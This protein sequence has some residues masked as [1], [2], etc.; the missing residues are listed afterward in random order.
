MMRGTF[1]NIR[2]KNEM[3]PAS[4]AASRVHYP[5][6]EAM[7]IYD[8]AMR[9]RRRRRAAGHL[10]R[11]GIRHRLVARLGGQ[12][13]AAARRARGDRRELRAHPP[14]QPDRHGRAAARLRRRHVV[15]RRSGS[16]ATRRVSLKG[17][18][19][20]KPRQWL[21]ADDHLCERREAR[22]AAAGARSTRSTS[23]TISATAASCTTCCARSRGTPLEALSHMLVSA[24]SA[25]DHGFGRGFAGVTRVV[26]PVE[27][28]WPEI[29]A[30]FL[31]C[32]GS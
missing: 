15:A 20:I 24:L 31:H 10:R 18:A 7:A 4:K 21:E 29:S 19:D 16:R 27:R 32:Y 22:G 23:S 12:G 14:L 13:H 28:F 8:A 2:I 5:S 26:T 6:G 3:V 17:L 30:R 1:A 11:Q 25:R 9:Y